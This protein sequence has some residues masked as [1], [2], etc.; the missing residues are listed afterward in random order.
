MIQN[1][2]IRRARRAHLAFHVP[3]PLQLAESFV[4]LQAPLLE[5]AEGDTHEK[6]SQ[7]ALL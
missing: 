3:G 7:G 5:L 6:K 2:F 1:C 4:L